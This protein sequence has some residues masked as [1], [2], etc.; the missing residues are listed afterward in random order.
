MPNLHE[1]LLVVD[2]GNQAT[3][4]GE[5]WPVQVRFLEASQPPLESFYLMNYLFSAEAIAACLRLRPELKDLRFRARRK[6]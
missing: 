6:W 1:L 2:H 3:S 5:D 4:S